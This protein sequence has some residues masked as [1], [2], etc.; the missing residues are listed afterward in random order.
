MSA[1]FS[2]PDNILAATE[3]LAAVILRSPP[4]AAYQQA[5]ERLNADIRS[6]ELLERYSRTQTELRVRQSQNAVTQADVDQLRALQREVQANRKIMDYAETQQAA[7]AYLPAVNQ[8][9]SQ[10]LGVDFASLAGPASC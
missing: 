10:L 3:Q 9:I 8:E 5:K 1:S 6:R 2:L 4:M 7:I